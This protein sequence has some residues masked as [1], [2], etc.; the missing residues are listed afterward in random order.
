M[1][2]FVHCKLLGRKLVRH[3]K[4]RERITF[5]RSLEN[6]VYSYFYVAMWVLNWSLLEA[7]SDSMCT[8]I[9]KGTNTSTETCIARIS[10][11]SDWY[12]YIVQV[13]VEYVMNSTKYQGGKKTDSFNH[14]REC[15]LNF[16]SANAVDVNQII[17]FWHFSTVYY[18][19]RN[20]ICTHKHR[21]VVNRCHVL[22]CVA[23]E[24]K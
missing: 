22:C 1:L 4:Q 20:D 6:N 11:A 9:G 14:F 2:G 12:M 21:K 18:I 16:V 13:H 10:S 23:N 15:G 5:K 17:W 8:H 7:S 3:E 24:C 19:L